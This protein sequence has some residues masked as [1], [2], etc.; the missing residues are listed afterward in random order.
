MG[1]VCTG[2][3]RDTRVCRARVRRPRGVSTTVS[4]D[5]AR[6]LVIDTLAP[7]WQDGAFCLDDRL[8]VEDDELYFFKVGAR[9]PLV[10]GDISYARFGGGVAGVVKSTG[11]VVWIPEIRVALRAQSLRMR[12]NPR[13]QFGR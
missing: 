4:Y 6:Q 8:I 2:R 10:S 5:E 3:R 1:R 11:M 13:P 9:E 7:N 12:R